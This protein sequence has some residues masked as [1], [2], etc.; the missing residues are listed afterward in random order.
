MTSC[1]VATYKEGN[2]KTKNI[3]KLL[4]WVVG[5]EGQELVEKSGYAKV[6]L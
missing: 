1:F 3:K 5:P 4:D 2:R 6:N